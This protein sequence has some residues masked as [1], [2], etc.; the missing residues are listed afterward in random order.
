MELLKSL[1]VFKVSNAADENQLEHIFYEAEN[2]ATVEQKLGFRL[3]KE[4]VSF[5][6]EVGYGFFWQ[7]HKD[8]FDRLLSPAQLAQITLKE[9][10]YGDDPDLELYDDLYQGD[11]LLFFEVNEGV[12]LAIDKADHNGRNKVYYFENKIYDSLE[13][14]LNGLI[15]NPKLTTSF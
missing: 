3:P 6:N 13:E 1:S 15:S 11:K 5:Y 4:L 7:K 14:F 10:F 12:F 2:L 8:S 9:D